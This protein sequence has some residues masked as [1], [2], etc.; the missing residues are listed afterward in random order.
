[1]KIIIYILFFLIGIFIGS[2]INLAIYRIPLKKDIFTERSFC[3][4]CNHKL[5]FWDLIPLFSYIFLKGKCRYCKEK[6]KIK[7][8]LIEL[9]SG[10]YIV[11]LYASMNFRYYFFEINK[12]IYFF[13]LIFSYVTIILISEIDKNNRTINKSVLIFG[14][15]VQCFYI[16]YSFFINNCVTYRYSV[17]LGLLILV[18]IFEKYLKQINKSNYYIELI[19]FALYINLIIDSILFVLVCLVTL[20]FSLWDKVI[21]VVKRNANLQSIDYKE[22]KNNQN[23]ISIAYYIG[24]LTLAVILIQNFTVYLT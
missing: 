21:K 15:I 3:P 10:I 2:F 17:F 1:M 8:F 18:L 11:L 5:V 13:S 9:L 24:F 12:I 20:I 22:E 4:N 7:Y 16:V 19:G 23:K 6:I 14:V